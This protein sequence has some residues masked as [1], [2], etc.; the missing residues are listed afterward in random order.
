[1]ERHFD[2]VENNC[3]KRRRSR[4]ADLE[5]LNAHAKWWCEEVANVRT[6][7]TLQQRPIDRFR[8]ERTYLMPLPG[9]RPE[10][11]H[12]VARKV[13][14][15]HCVA[16][17]TNRYSVSPRYVGCPA[18][19]RVFARRLE[20]LLDGELHCT[21][22]RS[23]ERHGRFVLAEHADEFKR[24]APSKH[25]LQESFLRLGD[26]AKTYYDG[27]VAQ[28]GSGAGYHLKRLLRLAD[29]HGTS[30]VVAA[31]AHAARYGAFSADAVSRILSGRGLPA[32]HT[33]P[34]K[35]PMP[36][37]RVRRWLEGL[38]VEGI[39][40]SEFDNRIAEDDDDDEA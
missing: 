13:G 15:D 24:H 21:H 16:I 31:M 34:G 1:M 18:T 32:T 7:G 26:G 4:F 38:E 10:A 27:L 2:Y 11:F 30:P 22:E 8:N 14:T 12:T 17:E 37:E 20:I 40:L 33:E 19:V 36:P 3:L 6:H 9:E 5:D 39:D 29:R 35:P 23:S 28:R 25:L